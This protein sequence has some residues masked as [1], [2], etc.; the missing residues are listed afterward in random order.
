MWTTEEQARQ[1]KCKPTEIAGAIAFMA[2]AP[3]DAVDISDLR[4]TASDCMMWRW[5]RSK[6]P[7]FRGDTGYCGLAGRP[8]D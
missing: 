2:Q 3:V 8:E 4:C 6:N 5:K 1:K 7:E